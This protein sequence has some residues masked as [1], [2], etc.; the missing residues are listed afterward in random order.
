MTAMSS[1]LQEYNH[2]RRLLRA[3]GSAPAGDILLSRP[4]PSSPKSPSFLLPA[5][6]FPTSRSAGSHQLRL[7][8]IEQ[9]RR[10]GRAS[11]IGELLLVYVSILVFLMLLFF[12]SEGVLIVVEAMDCRTCCL[13]YPEVDLYIYGSCL[14]WLVL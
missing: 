1:E 9:L 7:L 2:R 6:P 4:L 11:T 13:H 8:A 10:R 12:F 5:F 3:P 14:L